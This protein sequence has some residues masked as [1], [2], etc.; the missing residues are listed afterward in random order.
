[1]GI[2]DF[3]TFLEQKSLDLTRKPT[4]VFQMNI[5]IYCNQACNHCHVESSPR[6]TEMMSFE[7]AEQCLKVIRASPDISTVDITGGAP[8]LNDQFRYLVEEV[9]KMGIEIIDRCNLT[10]LEEPG[11][12]DLPE[13]LVKHKVRVVASLPCY[14]SKNVD[15]QRGKGVF[16]RSIRGVSASYRCALA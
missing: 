11:Q 8:E 2:P 7:V 9:S 4:T 16:G 14:S 12:E 10:V 3:Y 6:R 1:M 5:G 15:T 13:F